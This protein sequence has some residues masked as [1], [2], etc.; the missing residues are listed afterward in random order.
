[1]SRDASQAE[2]LVPNADELFEDNRP[3]IEPNLWSSRDLPEGGDLSAL[4]REIVEVWKGQCE[5]GRF[6]LVSDEYP[7]PPY[8]NGL[9]FEGW[10]KAPWKHDPPGKE[11]PFNYP[12]VALDQKPS[13]DAQ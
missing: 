7:N 1:L 6:T 3:L 9:Y 10:S 13:G 8:P 2:P 4:T 5:W 11:A 12:L